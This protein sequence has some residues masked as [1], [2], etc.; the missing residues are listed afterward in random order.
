MVVGQPNHIGMK[1]SDRERE[2]KHREFTVRSMASF[3]FVCAVLSTWGSSPN[4]LQF[5]RIREPK[6]ME[7]HKVTKPEL[8][9]RT[10]IV[11]HHPLEFDEIDW[12]SSNSV[13][14]IRTNAIPP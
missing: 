8:Q 9:R 6:V 14:S 4:A 12:P 11:K 13:V 10:T 2:A 3:L 1:I 5:D 7:V